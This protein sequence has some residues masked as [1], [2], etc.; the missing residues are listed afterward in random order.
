MEDLEKE[1][2]AQE[3]A[4]SRD[5]EIERVLSCASGDHFAV[6]DIWPGEDG[7]KAY[8]RKTILIHPDKTDNPQAP[9]A[10]DRLKKAERVVN[11]IKEND[12]EFY[13]ERERLESIYKH[14]G[15]DNSKPETRSVATRDEAAKVLKRE[16][17]KLETDQSIERYQQ[18]QENKRQMELQK[19]RLAKRKQDSVW[20]DQRDTRV[21]NW[22]NYVHKVDKKTK[23]KKKKVLA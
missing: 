12:E 13:L 10:F 22:R 21:Q 15:F 14:V 8:R 1:L 3:A 9:E 5:R 2:S 19:Q 20:E 4:L 17:A 23:K 18:E 11:A 16:K 7:K 6:L